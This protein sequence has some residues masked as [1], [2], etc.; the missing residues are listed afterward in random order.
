VFVAVAM[1]DDHHVLVMAAPAVIAI[2]VAM[3]AVL[4]ARAVVTIAVSDHD[5]LSARNRRHSYR[6]RT[7]CG[8][9]IS[10]LLHVVLL[11]SGED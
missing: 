8:K 10:K 6:Y 9:N 1:F 5:V 11:H 4:G 3:I 7:D 2:V